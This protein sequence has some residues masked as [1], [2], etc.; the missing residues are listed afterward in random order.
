M[1]TKTLKALLILARHRCAQHGWLDEALRRAEACAARLQ[2]APRRPHAERAAR[3][4]VAGPA[5]V[6]PAT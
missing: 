5:G 6:E 4:R 3:R 1:A 2:S